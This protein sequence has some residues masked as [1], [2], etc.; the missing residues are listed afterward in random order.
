MYRNAFC[1]IRS[2]IQNAKAYIVHEITILKP[3]TAENYSVV[4]VTARGSS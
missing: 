2:L 4:S 1:W 3:Q